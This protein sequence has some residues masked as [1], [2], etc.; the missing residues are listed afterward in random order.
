MLVARLHFIFLIPI[1]AIIPTT[2]AKIGFRNK[3]PIIIKIAMISKIFFTLILLE[4]KFSNRFYC[5]LN[6]F[7]SQT[8]ACELL[9]RNFIRINRLKISLQLYSNRVTCIF[10]FKRIIAR[11]CA[12]GI[13]IILQ[14]IFRGVK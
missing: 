14:V 10:E 5:N 11:N 1:N 8:G 9:Q 4:N 7:S 2:I 6:Y 13:D 12:I 3:S